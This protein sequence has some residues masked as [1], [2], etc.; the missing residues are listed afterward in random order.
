DL[1]LKQS[2]PDEANPERFNPDFQ[3][4]RAQPKDTHN[5]DDMMQLLIS[6]NDIKKIMKP[7]LEVPEFGH[8]THDIG[9]LIC[10]SGIGMSIVA[11]R[12]HE[13]RAGLCR[14]LK[15]AKMSRLHNDCNV[16]VFGT[17]DNQLDDMCEMIKI[18]IASDHEGGR[19]QR[20][21]GK[22]NPPPINPPLHQGDDQRLKN[23]SLKNASL[24]DQSMQNRF[25]QS[26]SGR[27]ESDYKSYASR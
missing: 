16:I 2:E 15:D 23:A 21:V 1:N 25:A 6:T 22:I 5:K 18:F 4:K 12:Y 9:I 17:L 11:N 10:G 24:Q 3:P 26:S 8:L 7:A 20:R 13:I 19:H 14:S 27:F